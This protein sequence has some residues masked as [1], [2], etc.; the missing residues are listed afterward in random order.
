MTRAPPVPSKRDS[1]PRHRSAHSASK[2]TSV[3]SGCSSASDL[4]VITARAYRSAR[5]RPS[6]GPLI[7][8]TEPLSSSSAPETRA[9]RS[10]RRDTSA[11]L[12][13]GTWSTLAPPWLLPSH[14][15]A[16]PR[17]VLGPAARL[18]SS[19]Q[20]RQSPPSSSSSSPSPFS[21]RAYEVSASGNLTSFHKSTAS[22]SLL[23][24]QAS[25]HSALSHLSFAFFSFSFFS[26][27]SFAFFWFSGF[28]RL[29][30]VIPSGH[31]LTGPT[32]A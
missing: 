27:L 7:L 29:E 12:L 14:V 24:C 15:P 4:S 5:L 3:M 20:K 1:F 16:A 21:S 8:S 32:G 17:R 2:G 22:P 26:F 11:I 9:S 28:S 23:D 31:Q 6:V 18:S 30:F 19:S 13:G 25:A 10:C